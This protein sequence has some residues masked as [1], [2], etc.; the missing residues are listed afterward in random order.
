MFSSKCQWNID[1]I[2]FLHYI[3]HSHLI[4][5]V[6][7]AT[8]QPNL[9]HCNLNGGKGPVSGEEYLYTRILVCILYP[10]LITYYHELVNKKFKHSI[11]YYSGS[12]TRARIPERYQGLDSSFSIHSIDSFKIQPFHPA[13]NIKAL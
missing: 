4:S 12:V 2:R 3:L 8:E 9:I 5:I 10:L 6:G 1:E 7:D 11:L 13:L